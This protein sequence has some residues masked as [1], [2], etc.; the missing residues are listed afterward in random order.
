VTASFSLFP[1]SELVCTKNV[2]YPIHYSLLIYLKLIPL[3]SV[4]DRENSSLLVPLDIFSLSAQGPTCRP[5][6]IG[7]VKLWSGR[8]IKQEDKRT[9]Q[10]NTVT[11]AMQH[12]TT[13]WCDKRRRRQGKI[14]W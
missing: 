5:N 9:E 6:S 2:S 7:L 13:S 10:D 1:L 8:P 11:D 12:A 4:P 3:W 14:I